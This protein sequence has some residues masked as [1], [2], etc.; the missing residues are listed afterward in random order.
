[1][2]PRNQLTRK[3]AQ[4]ATLVWHGLTN[5]EIAVTIHTSEQVVKN[6]LRSIFDKI[7]VW[8]RLELAMYVAQHGGDRWLDDALPAP[9]LPDSAANLPTLAQE[10]ER[11]R[12]MAG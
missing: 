1:M 8:S 6:Y 5:K 10:A 12:A 7:G 4:V 9:P 3:E 2:A 11:A